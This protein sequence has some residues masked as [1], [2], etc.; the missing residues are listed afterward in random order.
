M[1]MQLLGR[2][3]L[4]VLA[5][6]TCLTGADGA[7]AKPLGQTKTAD[8]D[9]ARARA[10]AEKESERE[11]RERAAERAAEIANGDD[12]GG[13]VVVRGIKDSLAEARNQKRDA[14]QIVD[15]IRAEDVGKLPA[16]TVGDVVSYIPGIQVGRDEGEVSDIQLRGLGGVQTTV[17]GTESFSSLDRNTFIQ[18][19]PADLV[20]SIEV[21]KTST[22]SQVEG[23][24]SGSININLRRPVDFKK[25][26]SV[27][28]IATGRYNNQSKKYFQNYTAIVNYRVDTPIGQ[29]GLLLNVTYNSNPFLESRA[30]ND[31]LGTVQTRQVTG[32]QILPFP[33]VAPNQVAFQYNVGTRTTKSYTA[34]AQWK[35]TNEL[36]IVL[37]GNYN[38]IRVRRTVNQLYMP[39]LT[40]ANSS[41]TLP[42]LSNISLVPGTNRIGSVTAS[43]VTQVGPINFSQDVFTDQYYG[44]FGVDY[45]TDFFSLNTKLNYNYASSPV[46]EQTIRNRF[47]NRPVYDVEFASDRFKFP[48]LNLNFR[49]LDLLDPN[50]YRFFQFDESKRV[51]KGSLVEA[52]VDLTLRPKMPLIDNIQIGLRVAHRT[53]DRQNRSRSISGLSIPA[54]QMP[55]GYNN[56]V[57][58]AQ[59]FEGTGVENNARWLG[60][61]REVARS[62]LPLLYSYLAG[63]E[64]QRGVKAPLFAQQLGPLSQ[65]DF[66]NGAEDVIAFYGQTRYSLELLFPIDGVIGARIVNTMLNLNGF[67]RVTRAQIVNGVNTTLVGFE[68]T[69]GR[70]NALDVN[71]SASMNIHFLKDLQLRL[72]YTS[73]IVRP[74]SYDLSP[75]LNFTDTASGGGAAD[76]GNPNLKP[77]Q[78]TKFDA[79]LEYYFG[80]TG[81]LTIAPFYWKL[82][83]LIGT[84]QSLEFLDNYPNPFTVNRPINAG[85]GY[86]R[87]VEVQGQT[88]FTF[89]PGI[90]ANFGVSGNFTYV[91]SNLNY[92]AREGVLNLP[93]GNVPI[94]GTA[95]KSAT[96]MGLFER[97][98]MS[99]RFIWN[100]RD[101]FITTIRNPLR[102][103]DYILPFTWMEAN[104]SYRFTK[105]SLKNLSVGAQA[106]NLGASARR[107]FYGYPDQ[108]NAVVYMART[109]GLNVRYNF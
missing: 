101:K 25:G 84:F 74:R 98:G 58:I 7:Q 67:N 45:D 18:D 81:I 60:Y 49:N 94:A 100:W 103:S 42:A 91:E 12:P 95:P 73:S 24:G 86:R 79:S 50:Q 85:A 57:A 17:N 40:Q 77:Q 34:S 4:M 47:V 56:L 8:R 38:A 55:D 31:P 88:F 14:D 75:Y 32:P 9:A 43:P 28:G 68:P 105:G 93:V 39:I 30:F 51:N 5:A 69:A 46:S 70:T 52:L 80:R 59:G 66:F 106:Q 82:S 89:L 6:A 26:L 10:K 92:P 63:I 16:N 104:V 19:L 13:D 64:Q 1:Q 22:P 78:T 107:T 23:S 65:S 21:Y 15:V 72:G 71:P 97:G 90:L 102:N 54:D 2:T 36:S 62:N 11:Q 99:G 108:P 41:N 33:T 27:F 83:G 87:G 44:R 29:M 3:S 109:Y 53:F 61:D 37:E 76:G 48:Q 96:I 20:K 35:P